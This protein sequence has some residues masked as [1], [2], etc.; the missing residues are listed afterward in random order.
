MNEQQYHASVDQLM[1]AIEEAIDDSGV[2]IDYENSAGMLTLTIE[3][4]GSQLIL[5]RQAAV[6]ELWLAIRAGGLHFKRVDGVWRNTVDEEPLLV[7][8]N[9]ALLEQGGEALPLVDA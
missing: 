9:R 2:D 8:L 7:R 1:L 5:S 4:N 3:A 6:G